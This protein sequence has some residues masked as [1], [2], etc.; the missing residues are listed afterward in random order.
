MIAS[1]WEIEK[2]KECVKAA[3]AELNEEKTEYAIPP[4]GIMIETPAAAVTA[5]ILSKKADFIS[6]G[7]NDLTQYTLALDREA[8]GLD[9]YFDAHHESVLRLIDSVIRESRK[10]NTKVGI[11]GALAADP[12]L[13]SRFIA[14]GVDELSVPVSK[15]NQTRIYA[16]NAEK[17]ISAPQPILAPCDG[18]QV[19]MADIPD[20]VFASGKLGKCVGI[21]PDN[22]SIYAPCDGTVVSIAQTL[23]ALTIRSDDGKEYLIHVGIN[24]VNLSGKGFTVLVNEGER[25]QKTQKIIEADLE[26][27]KENG[28]SAMVILVKL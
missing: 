16:A 24:T 3:A 10:N 12:A 2:I 19:P 20:P 8:S 23:H 5:D 9:R 28:Y 14:S 26:L 11:C 18:E 6:I 25:I 7:T 4:L 13:I 22:G 17:T 1:E 15:V 21:I 27:I